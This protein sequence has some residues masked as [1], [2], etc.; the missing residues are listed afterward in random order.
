MTQVNL[1]VIQF[2]IGGLIMAQYFTLVLF[3]SY[4]YVMVEE[5]IVLVPIYLRK[6]CLNY[7]LN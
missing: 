4:F 2:V 1:P 7:H 6:L 5:V 3:L